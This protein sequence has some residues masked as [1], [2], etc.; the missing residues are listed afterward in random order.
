MENADWKALGI[1]VVKKVAVL[2][3]IALIMVLINP[4][5]RIK[6]WG[7]YV[8]AAAMLYFVYQVY[9]KVV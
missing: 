7:Q 1:A 4:L 9:G 6:P 2:V 5:V 8:H 3:G